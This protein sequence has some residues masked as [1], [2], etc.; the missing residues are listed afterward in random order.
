MESSCLQESLAT[1]KVL[2]ARRPKFLGVRRTYQYAA[3]TR[4]DPSSAVALLRRMEGNVADD[5]LMVHQGRG[6]VFDRRLNMM[7]NLM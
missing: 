4:D 1:S 3:T 5:A 2:D 6:G 7:Y